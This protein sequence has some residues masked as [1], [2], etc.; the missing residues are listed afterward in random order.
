MV[1]CTYNTIA[2]TF[3][4]NAIIYSRKR[5]FAQLFSHLYKKRNVKALNTTV[6]KID[7]IAVLKFKLSIDK[8]ESVVL[9]RNH[10]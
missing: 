2:H 7:L 9:Q 8:I 3:D 10:D 4:A 1:I 5:S 6:I